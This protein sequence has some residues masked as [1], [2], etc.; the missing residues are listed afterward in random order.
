MSYDHM[1]VPLGGDQLI[2]IF[3]SKQSVGRQGRARQRANEARA[4]EER[5]SDSDLVRA[6]RAKRDRKYAKERLRQ[7][8]RDGI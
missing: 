3:S 2:T 1:Y 5:A 4:A 6:K 8:R 7:M